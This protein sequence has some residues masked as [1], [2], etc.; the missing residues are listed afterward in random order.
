MSKSA[1]DRKQSLS[2]AAKQAA[3]VQAEKAIR[4][5]AMTADETKAIATKTEA[6]AQLDAQLK[7]EAKLS[8]VERTQLLQ[9]VTD[10]LGLVSKAK[11]EGGL[12]L[13]LKKAIKDKIESGEMLGAEAKGL[14][15]K[16]RTVCSI[17][18][19]LASPQ[20]LSAAEKAK[21]IAEAWDL[22]WV[23]TEEQK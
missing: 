19:A 4:T 22:L 11:Q 13:T 23:V 9:H 16:A 17:R 14:I 21:R 5:G 20:S 7:P 10:V 1:A 18:Q 8:A 2:D 6:L 12:G 15:Q 3:L